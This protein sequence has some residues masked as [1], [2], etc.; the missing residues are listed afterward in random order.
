MPFN[1]TSNRD[2][3]G[4]GSGSDRPLFVGRNS[5]Y[6]PHRWNIDAR[7][8]RFIPIRKSMRAE[9]IAELKNLFNIVQVQGV[10]TTI[11]VDTQGN[12]I[13]PIPTYVSSYSNPG[14]FVPNGGFEQREFQIGFKF[15]F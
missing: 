15:Y 2:L 8:S 10:N 5:M 1:I 6:Y 14:G 7:F 3:N 11:Q 4:D 9:V 13:N 12:P